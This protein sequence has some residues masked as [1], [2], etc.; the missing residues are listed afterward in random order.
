MNAVETPS[1]AAMFAYV[2]CVALRISS[3]RSAKIFLVNIE[4]TLVYEL[5]VNN[6]T[7]ERIG[8]VFYGRIFAFEFTIILHPTLSTASRTSGPH[9]GKR[10]WAARWKRTN[11]AGCAL[12]S[13][14]GSGTAAVTTALRPKARSAKFSLNR[15]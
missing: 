5:K 11:C 14:G 8:N 15:A 1:A 2:V 10:C 9:T 6:M 13:S 3:K 7:F 4:I 12:R